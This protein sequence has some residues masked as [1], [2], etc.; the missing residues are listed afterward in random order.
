MRRFLGVDGALCIAL[1][2]VPLATVDAASTLAPLATFGEGDGL[3]APFEILSG[4]AADTTAPDDFFDPAYLY[5]GNA[6]SNTATVNGGNLE[7]GLAYNPTTGHLLLVSRNDSGNSRVSVRILDGQTGVDLGGLDQGAAGFVT[8]G[9]FSRNMIGV[10]DDGAI[11]MANLATTISGTSPYKVY[12]WSNE[13]SAP[14]VAYSGTGA[15]DGVIAGARL[16]DT[17]DVYGGGAN[18]RLVAGYGAT[19]A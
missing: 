4:D 15:G 10:A 7:R 3:R 9:A 13:S 17:F 16:G 12:R 18:T 6:L 14:T 2:V 11:Y 5:L 19:S 8:G 1:L